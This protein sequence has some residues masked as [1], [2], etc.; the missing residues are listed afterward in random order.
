L[1]VVWWTGTKLKH[2]N[3]FVVVVFLWVFLCMLSFLLFFLFFFSCFFL[4]FNK[5]RLNHHLI[6]TKVECL[7]KLSVHPSLEYFT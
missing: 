1:K 5:W 7:P 6:P 3:A 2:S 4:F